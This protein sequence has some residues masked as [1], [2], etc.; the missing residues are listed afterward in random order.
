MKRICILSIAVMLLLP[1][2][3]N[4]RTPTTQRRRL[5]P[6]KTIDGA[7][8]EIYKRVGDVELRLHIFEPQGHKTSNKSPAIVFFFG[9]GWNSGSPIQFVKQSEYLASRGMVAIVADYRVRSRHKVHVPDC[10]EDAKSA[11][12]WVRTS[13]KRLGID[14]DRIAAGGGS[15]GGHL[16]ASTGT[17][18]EYDS[19]KE[20]KSVSSRPNAMLLFNPAL[21]LTPEGFKRKPDAAR[22][23]SL[24]ERMGAPPKNI[25]PTYHVTDKTPPTIIF[26]GT[27][28][29]TVPYAQVTAFAK[30]MKDVHG[31]CEVAAFE[32]QGHG[33][34]NY[35][36]DKH[37]FFR[38]TMLKADRFLQALGYIKGEATINAFLKE[39]GSAK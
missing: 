28:D 22:Y 4:A 8:T 19:P 23:K 5:A 9:G 36:R 38:E 6:P 25:S 18:A 7:K 30:A 21:D 32:G 17:I 1:A 35:G 34:F 20:D 13:A 3:L 33:F 27:K 31:R 26:H 39:K 2:T 12:R 16:A 24:A 10:I 37:K 14:P 29:T 15:A 11:I